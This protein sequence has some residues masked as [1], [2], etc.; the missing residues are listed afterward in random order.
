MSLRNRNLR[1]ITFGHAARDHLQFVI[2]LIPLGIFMY[3]SVEQP[4]NALSSILVIL[5]G[6]QMLVRLLQFP[7]VFFLLGEIKHYPLFIYKIQKLFD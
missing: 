5:L 3:L 7:N 2:A 4:E 6:M 1:G